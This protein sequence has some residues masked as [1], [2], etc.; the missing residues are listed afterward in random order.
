[1]FFT[2]PTIMRR[3]AISLFILAS[4]STV[5][6]A[7]QSAALDLDDVI[8]LLRVSPSAETRAN[9][10]RK[11]CVSFPLNAGATT[12]L[13]TAGANDDLLDVIRNAC[14]TGT[15][16]VVDSRPAG[17]EVLVDGQP[18]GKA[19]WTGRYASASRPLTITARLNGSSQTANAPLDSR[20]RVKAMFGFQ[21]DTVAVPAVRTT[22]EIVS[23]LGLESQ[24]RPTVPPPDA[25]KPPSPYGNFLVSTVILGATAYGGVQYCDRASSGC[26]FKVELDEDGLDTN[27]PYRKLVGGLS[28]AIVGTVINKFIGMSVNSVRRRSYEGNR[29]DY[30]KKQADWNRA[31]DGARAEWLRTHPDVRRVMGNETSLRQKAIDEN[32]ETKL[33]NAELPP[34]GV[35]VEPIGNPPSN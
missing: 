4:S 26:G 27:D 17:A 24:W 16:V 20:K 11:S 29:A 2:Q 23:E 33:R 15:E 13:K 12:R 8:E 32:R 3:I 19:P 1:M 30:L 14:F 22:A 31:M 35:T 25:P 10:I 34:S 6:A 18:V 21:K 9:Y 7:Q 28:G 5:A